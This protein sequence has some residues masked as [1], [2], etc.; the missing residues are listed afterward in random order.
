MG[1]SVK[2]FGSRTIPGD[3]TADNLSL[4]GEGLLNDS[5]GGEAVCSGTTGALM[6]TGVLGGWLVSIE[7]DIVSETVEVSND[8]PT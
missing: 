3:G 2:L 7:L 6:S 5:S 1:E 4:A 8:K